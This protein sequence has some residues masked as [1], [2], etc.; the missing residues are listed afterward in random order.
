[1]GSVN[2]E[3]VRSII[4]AWERGDFSSADWAHP[5]IEYVVADSADAGS[6][7]GLPAMAESVRGRRS[8]FEDAR[9]VAKNSASS[10]TSVCSC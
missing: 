8:A 4:A 5:E 9:V 3:L 6:W 1:V 10:M 2:V 7:T